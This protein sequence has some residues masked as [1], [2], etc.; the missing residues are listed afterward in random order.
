MEIVD[1]TLRHTRAAA[2][3]YIL[4]LTSVAGGVLTA[5]IL[6]APISEYIETLSRLRHEPIGRLLDA[7]PFNQ[8]FLSFALVLVSGFAGFIST[9]WRRR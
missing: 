4:T 8:E 1:Q 2:A 3:K 7:V 9:R 6:K 5:A